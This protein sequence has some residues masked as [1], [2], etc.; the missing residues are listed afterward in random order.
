MA[1]GIW[2]NQA[3]NSNDLHLSILGLV[4]VAL[5]FLALLG[6]RQLNRAESALSFPK[7]N[8][9][10]VLRIDGSNMRPV[11]LNPAAQKFIND[12]GEL[13]VEIREV[14]NR[15]AEDSLRER[16]LVHA[17]MSVGECD[18]SVAVIPSDESQHINIYCQDITALNSAR[19]KVEYEKFRASSAETMASIGEIASDVLHDANNLI[20]IQMLQAQQVMSRISEG[21][22]NQEQLVR[23]LNRIYLAGTRM[24]SL[25]GGVLTMARSGRNPSG[26]SSSLTKVILETLEFC[27]FRFNKNDITITKELHLND[28]TQAAISAED[29]MRVLMNLLVNAVDAIATNP[30]RWIK[31]Q[32]FEINQEIQVCITD[33]GPGI[34][35]HIANDIFK[36]LFTTKGQ[37]MG[38][39]LGLPLSLRLVE[40]AGGKLFLNKSFANTQFIICLPK[41][42][43]AKVAA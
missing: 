39:G 30:D 11:F 2:F 19:R 22:H 4:G 29:F 28:S 42:A 25:I 37:G 16:T 33:S 6:I 17:E 8:P 20:T 18:Y 13:H 23:D 3:L 40:A 26:A 36:P 15:L 7:A 27:S 41:L 10:P 12:R 38:T 35:E 31:V 34:P 14:L 9:F 5:Y 43:E 24:A 32:A 1:I 21:E